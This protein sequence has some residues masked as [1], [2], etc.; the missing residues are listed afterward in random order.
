MFQDDKMKIKP[1]NYS[2]NIKYYQKDNHD[3]NC[4]KFPTKMLMKDRHA[5]R[6][7]RHHF[8]TDKNITETEKQITN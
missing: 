3:L 1:P 8:K 2:H 7:K 5:I 4:P 6:C